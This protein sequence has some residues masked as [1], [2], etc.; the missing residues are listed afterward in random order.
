MTSK[1]PRES[2]HRAFARF[3]I[4]GIGFTILGPSL[5]WLAYPL[6]P[7]VALFTAEALVHVARFAAFRT[8]VF[9]AKK[10]YRVS[11][12][13]YIISVLPVTLAGMANVI[14][15]RHHLD[16][17]SLSLSG[18]LIALMAGFLW[19][20]HVYSKPVPASRVERR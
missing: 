12:R 4:S 11:L 8:V 7:F 13:R 3:G 18:A 20:R 14:L 6:G 15:L 5:F 1:T 17:T 16:R 2:S 9:P 19:S 10:G